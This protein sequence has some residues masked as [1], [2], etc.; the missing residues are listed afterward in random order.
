[1]CVE[2]GLRAGQRQRMLG[3]TVGTGAASVGRGV[4]EEARLGIYSMI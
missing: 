1:M 3:I 4:W 2:E